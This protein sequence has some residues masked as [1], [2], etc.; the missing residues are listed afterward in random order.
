MRNTAGL[1]IAHTDA[2]PL[3]AF[4]A[5]FGCLMLVHTVRLHIH[6]MYE[7][8]V[9]R[10]QF[11]F[12]YS[13]LGH[14]LRMPLRPADVWGARCHLL[15]LG[16]SS[17]GMALGVCTRCCATLF[18]VAYTAFVLYERTMFNN[19][20]YLYVLLAVLIAVVGADQTLTLRSVFRREGRSGP[21]RAWHLWLLQWQVC[22][23]YAYAGVAKLNSDWL[24]HW[25]PMATKLVDEAAVYNPWMRPL[26]VQP[27]TAAVVSLGGACFDLAIGPILLVSQTRKVGLLTATGFH[28]A[29]HCLWSLGEFPWVMIASGLLFCTWPAQERHE[30]L[31]RASSHAGRPHVPPATT[32]RWTTID[33]APIVAALPSRGSLAF[34]LL[35]VLV[36]ALV[37]LRPLWVSDGDPLDAVHTKTHTLLSWRMMAVSTRNF[38]NVTMRCDAMGASAQMTRTYNHLFLLHANGSRQQL[39]LTPLLEPRQAGYMPYTPSMLVQFARAAGARHRCL[40]DEGCRV[41]G[42]LWSAINGRPLQRF[43]DPHI[44]LATAELAEFTRPIWVRPLL[45]EFGNTTWRRRFAWLHARL[46]RSAH[47]VA[48]F[49]DAPNGV[50][51]QAFPAVHS[52]PAR[53]LIV[54]L[55]G[56][57]EVSLWGRSGNSDSERGRVYADSE[58]SA[59]S[60]HGPPRSFQMEPPVW[61]SN[62]DGD[63]EMRATSAPVEVPFGQAHTVRTLGGGPSCWCYVFGVQPQAS[64]GDS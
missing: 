6:G 26:L 7:R 51:R 19:H 16:A 23:V 4:R 38:I 47:Q 12:L 14:E 29:N 10:P 18:A 2:R 50:F 31:A 40:P 11:N 36:Q 28:I 1:C 25:Q 41:V 21:A 48:F 9:V 30:P 45:H 43:V 37:P 63:P 44:D 17:M 3:C 34:L 61:V 32:E 39:T 42:D 46:A 49:A 27:V 54:P 8:S 33:D 22:V 13:V 24:L 53:A 52:F 20:Y 56:R 5:A 62:R 60:Q 59:S 55:H 57:I 64:C 15:L 35:F 58:G